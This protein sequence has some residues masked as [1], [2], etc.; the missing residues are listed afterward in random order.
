MRKISHTCPGV[1][2]FFSC[3]IAI[4]KCAMPDLV[5]ASA[6]QWPQVHSPYL[7]TPMNT[8]FHRHT[9]NSDGNGFTN[10]LTRTLQYSVK[11]TTANSVECRRKHCVGLL[12]CMQINTQ[13]RN[14]GLRHCGLRGPIE[15]TPYHSSPPSPPLPLPPLRSI[16]P[17]NTDR[18]TGGA[19]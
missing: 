9:C 6:I 11:C 15:A 17:L 7:Q 3:R 5:R 1:G 4:R 18:G 2:D 14:S 19:L 13:V 10:P 8:H 16:E 12:Y